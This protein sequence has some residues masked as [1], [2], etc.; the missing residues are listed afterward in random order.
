M[1]TEPNGPMTPNRMANLAHGIWRKIP[2]NFRRAALTHA[3]AALAPKPDRVPPPATG[4]LAVGGEFSRASGI[5][6]SARLMAAAAQRFGIPVWR[7]DIAPPVDASAEL[8]SPNDPAPPPGAPIVFHINAP[9]LPLALLRLP[10]G[11]IK[12]R[13]VIGYWFWELPNIPPDWRTGVRFVHDI[14]TLSRFTAAALEPLKPGGVRV[15]PPP[16][17]DAP[18]VP[19][20][21]DRSAFGLPVDAVVTLVSFNLASSFARKNP[22]AAIAA[23]RQAFG[24]RPDRILVLKVGHPDHA[25]ADFQRLRELADAPNIRI[26]TRSLPTADSHALTA[27]CDIVLSLHRSEG[28]G[29]VPAEAMFLGKPVVATG[30]SGNMDFMTTETAALVGY[31]LIPV[32]DDRMVYRN[33]VWADPDIG[34]AA[35]HLRRLADDA[36]ERAALGARARAHVG[37]VLTSEPL[38]AAMR[39]LGLPVP[40]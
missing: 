30:W 13:R 26:E 8:P 9:L 10:R 17:A 12:N 34:E 25:P 16:L 1:P 4:G 37:R 33:S 19:A 2:P 3:T 23:F 27:C 29:L 15:V 18:P 40:E 5:G 36:Q 39:D 32:H 7:T 38:A 11:L 14:W 6:E 31:S 21:A 20:H 22:Q 35:R 24:D 28:F